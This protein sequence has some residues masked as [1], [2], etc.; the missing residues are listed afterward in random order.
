MGRD[1]KAFH[2]LAAS[3]PGRSG[4]RWA[5]L[6]LELFPALLNGLQE[7]IQV[8]SALPRHISRKIDRKLWSGS[9]MEYHVGGGAQPL[10][11]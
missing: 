1:Q 6:E 5:R 9:H 11:L 3:P 7:V 8:F 10:M 2:L 4:Q